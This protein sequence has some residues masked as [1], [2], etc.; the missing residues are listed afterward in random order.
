MYKNIYS[1]FRLCSIFILQAAIVGCSNPIV[2]PST[3]CLRRSDG[4]GKEY[5]FM[6]TIDA[7]QV[8]RYNPHNLL[9]FS[10]SSRVKGAVS[11]YIFLKRNSGMFNDGDFYICSMGSYSPMPSRGIISIS[12]GRAVIDIEVGQWASAAHAAPIPAAWQ[13]SRVNGEYQMEML[14]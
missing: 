5:P 14:P 3:V 2:M 4:G 7:Y 6:L 13:K 8:M 10:F 9:E 12:N 1:L 11:Y